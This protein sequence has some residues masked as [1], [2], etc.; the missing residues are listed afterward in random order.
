MAER[1][2]CPTGLPLLQPIPADERQVDLEHSRGTLHRQ[3]HGRVGR[4]QQP[5]L[6]G[7]VGLRQDQPVHAETE[8]EGPVRRDQVQGA[9]HRRR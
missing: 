7:D 1:A 2:A 3:V 5:V 6:R 4:L 8:G 9:D